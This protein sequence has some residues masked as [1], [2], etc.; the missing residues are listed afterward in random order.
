MNIHDFIRS[1]TTIDVSNQGSENV[2]WSAIVK[3][4]K[5]P[6]NYGRG[7][8]PYHLEASSRK[9]PKKSPKKKNTE[10]H[11][12]DVNL[13]TPRA[14]SKRVEELDFSHILPAVRMVCRIHSCR[15]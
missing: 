2:S 8:R 10:N 15:I 5:K 7:E 11:V 4:E 13:S 12:M 14:E 1:K 6:V 3:N 9:P